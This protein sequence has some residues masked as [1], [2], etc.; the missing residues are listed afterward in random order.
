VDDHPAG[1]AARRGGNGCRR[2]GT[3]DHR[4]G[5]TMTTALE[6]RRGDTMRFEI[7]VTDDDG[8]VDLTGRTLFFTAR[9]RYSDEAAVIEKTS[10][11]GIEHDDETVGL[12]VLTLAPADTE[13]MPAASTRLVCDLQLVDAAGA[14]TT[15][16][17]DGTGDMTLTVAPDVTVRTAP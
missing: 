2:A 8:P 12:A 6:M 13:E 4:G 17:P 5:L 3:G 9:R 10:G 7:E 1:G 14:V 16:L 11:A 15:L